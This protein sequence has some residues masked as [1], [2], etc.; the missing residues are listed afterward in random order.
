M[1]DIFLLEQLDA[2]A[3]NGTLTSAAEELHITQP[4]LSRNMK[5][6]EEALG[7]SLFNRENSKISLNETGKVAAEYAQRALKANQEVI[8]MTLAFDRRERSLTLGACTILPI[9]EILP[10]LQERFMDKAITTELANRE[11]M[12]AGLR[13]RNYQLA[14]FA[15]LPEDRDLYCQR[16]NED[17]LCVSF[18]PEH[19]LAIKEAITFDDLKDI[20]V[21]AAGNAGY[22]IYVCEQHMPQKNLVVQNNVEALVELVDS[23]SMPV[24]SSQHLVEQGNAAPGRVTVPVL[25]EAAHAVF[26][27][28]CLSSEKQKYMSLFNAVRAQT[29]RM[30]STTIPFLAR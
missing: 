29:I 22:W 25:D 23:S 18:P 19:P 5:K 21:I 12:L 20:S 16:F 1:L 8:D 24:F 6:L 11:Q 3:R 28:A 14:I 7:V 2:F 10:L 30:T 15:D 9:Y 27:L 13:S 17:R 4:A 26:Y